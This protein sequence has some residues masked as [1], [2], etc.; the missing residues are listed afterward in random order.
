MR[1][2]RLT[3]RIA[4]PGDA[5]LATAAA[6]LIRGASEGHDVAVRS[7]ALLRTK[8]ET[9][10]A[11][12][13]LRDGRLAGFG[14][15]AVWEDGEVVSHSGLVVRPEERGRGLG[16]RIKLRLL[17]ASRRL[18]P[19]ARTISLTSSPAVLAMNR[20]LGFRRVPLS[21]LTRDPRF[22][23]GCRG[24]RR[25]AEARAAGRRCCCSGMLLAPDP[26]TR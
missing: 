15:F 17:R 14:Y 9:G 2:A 3:V 5:R 11:V 10:R 16:R 8:L 7:P 6:A 12:V 26:G 19:R 21:R 22:W 18:F 20:S 1:A 24:C 23:E 25:F 13:A 4:R